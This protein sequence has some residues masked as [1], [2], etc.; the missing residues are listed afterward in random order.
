MPL[1]IRPRAIYPRLSTPQR[2][3][4]TDAATAT[5]IAAIIAFYPSNC[6]PAQVV[7]ACRPMTADQGRFTLF[8]KTN[9]IYGL[10]MMAIVQTSADPDLDL[11][12]QCVTFY[13][14]NNAIS[15]LIRGDSDTVIISVLTRIFWAICGR[16]GIAP[17]LESVPSGFNS[18]DRPT[19][20]T[21]LPF[22]C[23]PT[24]GFSYQGELFRMVTE[25]SSANA[26]G[27]FGPDLLV[28]R[29]Y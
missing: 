26:S 27:Y 6:T 4:Y 13:I 5:R 17:F 3:I 25:G 19:R 2:I 15:A 21:K 28:G 12:G 7:E 8:D 18:A 29:F 9:L 16:M 10:E 23:K 22:W 24:D 14:D 20:I 1:S 11:E